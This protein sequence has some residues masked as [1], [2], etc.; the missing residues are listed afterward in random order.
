VVSICF[1]GRLVYFSLQSCPFASFA[2]WSAVALQFF[3][4]SLKPSKK[5]QASEP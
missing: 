4:L 2:T 3:R 1:L 5:Q